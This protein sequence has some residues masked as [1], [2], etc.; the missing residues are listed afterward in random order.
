MKSFIVLTIL[1]LLAGCSLAP[2]IATPPPTVPTVP[3]VS[4]LDRP[5]E[6]VSKKPF[7]IFIEPAT[8]PVQ[9]ERF[10][11]YHTGVDFEVFEE[12]R[13][14]D[15]TVRAFCDGELITKRAVSGYGGVAI[16]SCVIDDQP[17]TVLYGHLK[18]SSITKNV[19]DEFTAGETL[20]GLG[21]AYS[22]ETDGERKHLHFAIHKGG[23]VELRGY[24]SSQSALDDWLDPQLYL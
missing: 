12:E 19:G 5:T 21:D 10:R 11:G 22:P 6:R 3:F 2:P 14:V 4:P 1:F 16:Q 18:L 8:S 7:G 17:V 13:D 15:V 9:P 20:G 24:V 23:A